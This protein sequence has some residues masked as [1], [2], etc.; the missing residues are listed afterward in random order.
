[1]YRIFIG[2]LLN[3]FW[4]KVNSLYGFDLIIYINGKLDIIW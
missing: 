1:M 4:I 2:L 3:K